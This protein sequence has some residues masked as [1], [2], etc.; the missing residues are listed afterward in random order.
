MNLKLLKYLLFA[1]LVVGANFGLTACRS[2]CPGVDGTGN[3]ASR[4]S[5]RTFGRTDC[6]AISGTG[7][8]KPKVKLKRE[9]GLMSPKMKRKMAKANRKNADPIETKRLNFE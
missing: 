5:R 1:L 9:V 2:Y 8:Y 4:G 7:N 6:P 3:T